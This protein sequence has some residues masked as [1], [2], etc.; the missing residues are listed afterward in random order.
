VT[1]PTNLSKL[2]ATATLGELALADTLGEV[3]LVKLPPAKPRRNQLVY[4]GGVVLAG[5]GSGRSQ[6][7]G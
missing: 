5:R 3:K 6:K 7:V 4:T 1:N 2:A